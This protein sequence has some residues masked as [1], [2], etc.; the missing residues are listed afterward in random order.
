MFYEPLPE[1]T[2]KY[3]KE[4]KNLI[5]SKLTMIYFRIK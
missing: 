3:L 2:K 1:D 5:N 4:N